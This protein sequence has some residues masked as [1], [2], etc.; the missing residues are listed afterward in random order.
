MGRGSGREWRGGEI[1]RGRERERVKRERETKR[2]A[3]RERKREREGGKLISTYILT[4]SQP[5]WVIQNE[6]EKSEWKCRSGGQRCTCIVRQYTAGVGKRLHTLPSHPRL[7]EPQG[8]CQG[9]L[10]NQQTKDFL[11]A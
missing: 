7:V 2:E 11:S 4:S 1:Q 6:R 5:Y 9:M 3:T 10:T 8:F